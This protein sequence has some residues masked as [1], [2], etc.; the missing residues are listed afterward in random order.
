MLALPARSQTY[1][2]VALTGY[3]HD[4]IAEGT[5]AVPGLTTYDVDGSNGTGYTFMSANYV[6]PSNAANGAANKL[7]NNGLI[8][9]IAT[10]TTG[11]TFQLAGYAANNVL[12]VPATGNTGGGTGTGADAGT[13]SFATPAPASTVYVLATGGG[14]A[15]TNGVTVTITFSDNTTQVFTGQT[16]SDWFSP[17]GATVAYQGFGRV[18]RTAA[19]AI[20]NASATTPNLYQLAF[21]I[22]PA[23]VTKPIASI[24][25][26][27]TVTATGVIDVFA[28]STATVSVC[29]ATPTNLSAAAT[30]TSGGSTPLT[31]ACPSTSIYLAVTGV[32]ATT[33]GYTYQWQASTT[34]ATAGFSNISGATNATYTATNQTA[35][36][37]YRVLVTCLYDGAGGTAV[38]SAAVQVTQNAPTSCYCVPAAHT[39]TTTNYTSVT[40]V[41]LPGDGGATLTNSPGLVASP[42]YAQYPASTT[43]TSLSING[44]YTLT[45]AAIA[46]QRISA[47]I[48]YNQDGA[49]DASE[50]YILRNTSGAVYGTSAG[51]LTAT[52]VPPAS[53]LTGPTRLRLR[54]DYFSNTV[55]NTGTNACAITQYGQ[56]MDYTVSLTGTACSGT[57]AA[58]TVSASAT[59][60][61]V[62]TGL[63]L[64]AALPAGVTGLTLQW[65]SRPTGTG[66]FSNITGATTNPYTV[67]SQTAG[68]DYRL[69][70]TCPAGGATPSNVVTV[71]QSPFLTCY[72]TPTYSSGG[73]NDNITRV[74]LDVLDNATTGNAS[75]YYRDYASAQTG[76]AATLQV[77]TLYAGTP[78]TLTL[79]FGSDSNQYNGVWV[80]FNQNGVFET[81]EFFTSAT[82]AG[83]SGTATVT[84]TIPATAAVVAGQTKM[85]IRGGDDSQLTGSQAC[86]AS[87][88]SYGEAEDYLVNIVSTPCTSTPPALTATAS[89]ASVCGG[90]SFTLSATGLAAGTT[91]V[92]Y[93]WQSSPAG[94][95]TFVNLGAAQASATYTVTSQT[96]ATDYRVI[97]TCAG[98]GSATTSSVV[99]VA[100]SAFLSCYC[101]PV[102]TG[103]NEY[104]KSVTLPGTPGF[105]NASGA[106]STNGYGDFTADPTL[107][108]TLVAGTTYSGSNGV[109]VTVRS[110][111]TNSQGGI[112]IDYDHSGTFDASEYTLLGTSSLQAT[113]VTFSGVTLAVPAT[114]LAGPTRARVR[115]RNSAFTSADACT[116][117]A[118]GWYGET[119]DYLVSIC[120]PSTAS[121]SYGSAS[122][123]VSGSTNPTISLATG[124]TAGTFSSTTGLTLNATT[125]AITL[126]T[127]TPGTYTVTNTVSGSCN[128]PGTATVTINAAPT[129]GFSYGAGP[130]CVSGSTNPTAT[131]AGG[132]TA[133]TFSSTAGLTLNATTGAVTLSTSTPGTY[134][135]TNTVAAANGC[136]SISSTASVTI[137]AAPTAAFSF[138]TATTCAG[139]AATLTPTL[140]TGATA[141]AF[142]LPTATGLTVNA[143]TGAITVGA[144]ATAGTYTVTNT[145]AASG[146]CAAVTSTAT[147]TL[148]APSTATFSYPAATYCR[149]STATATPTIT[150]TAGGTFT[151]ATG[152]SI[153]A[154]TG[155]ITPGTSTA[156]TYTVTYTVSGA[157]GSSSTQP[158]TITA[159]PTATFSY[160]TPGTGAA[161]A[162]GTGSFTPTI[163]GTG[164]TF[165]VAPAGLTVNATTG[166]ISLTGAPAGTYTITNT[167]AASGG[168]AAVTGTATFTVNALPA[169][170]TLTLSGT[171]ATGI[172]LTSSAASGNQFYLNNVAVPGATGTSYLINSGTRNGSY[173]VTVTNAS[174]CSATSAPVSVV[175]TATSAARAST[176]LAVYPNPTPDGHLL[177]EL[178]G[179][180]EAVSVRVLNAVGQQ[181]YAGTV[182]GS[183]PSRKQTLDLSAL[184]S[185]VYI[186]QARTA[187]GSVDVRRIVRE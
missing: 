20:D 138:P 145:V 77:P 179:Y 61:C 148:T 132:A 122:Y 6:N 70:L 56:T 150:G 28:V 32:P 47:W 140:G 102:S 5:G 82:N 164:G 4:V 135:V 26:G 79:N 101:A 12:R 2:P 146:G 153:N 75:P 161:C 129:A 177:L 154:S 185:G 69:L 66:T 104:V 165:S 178:T 87:G 83:A 25:F 174:G 29:A 42:Y 13:I 73:T 37:Y 124:A 119:E 113:D 53:A 68:T 128:A 33:A 44:S 17:S 92:T 105:T 58:A 142:T 125:G 43:T 30:T 139:S 34:S 91:G 74:R 152:L 168:C 184:P 89:A 8:T 176:A 64:S 71:A 40:T 100:Q 18:A 182:A 76:S 93:Q 97:A 48:D 118:T 112:W 39:S 169:T 7:P 162:G 49:F 51:N 143:T 131:L 110:N 57:P 183:A 107:T 24:T 166:A 59:T 22:L 130:Y 133:G 38:P 85:R 84:I 157:C 95:N 167:V 98:G 187:S 65:Q 16:I 63:V 90:G 117:G 80:D 45:V 36:T 78:A 163:T 116:G 137:T 46:N 41:T 108:T 1:T 72:C 155:V 81:S 141:G 160:A 52:I 144:T 134:T 173:T 27:K 3:N 86:G 67:A 109:S 120:Q 35:T 10:G 15:I 121:F 136:A 115:W 88:S 111:A 159:A 123:C 60:V 14:G 181:V 114:A 50:F 96:A 99:S 62:G 156:G 172:T 180:Q 19:S 23:N 149:S 175:V 151:S 11:L 186:L 158:V 21:N 171:P 31:A 55:L 9:S 103:I 126:S 94:A 170:P 54:S 127:S 147:F 106:N